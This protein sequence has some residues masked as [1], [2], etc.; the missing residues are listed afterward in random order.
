MSNW[1]VTDLYSRVD[2]LCAARSV[3]LMVTISGIAVM[4]QSLTAEHARGLA[5]DTV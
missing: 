3:Y 5:E 2:M 4:A 1:S